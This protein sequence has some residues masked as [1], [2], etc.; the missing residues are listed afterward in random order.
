MAEISAALVKELRERTGAGMMECKQALVRQKGDLEAAVEDLR[1]SGLAKAD[2]KAG[3]QTAEGRIATARRDDATVLLEVN[4][5]TDFVGKD[6]H[7]V[8]FADRLAEL[9]VRH[10]SEDTVALSALP[11]PQGGTVE[12]ARRHLVSRLGEN[13]TLRRL[14]LSRWTQGPRDVYL[15]GHR[16]G[17]LVEL[18]GGDEELAHDIAMH[19]AASRPL[20]VRPDEVPAERIEAERRIFQAQAAESGKPP[21]IVQKMVEG[22]VQKFLAEVT[23]LG[24]PF[25]KDPQTT[26]GDLL[27]R[28]KASVHAFVRMELGEGIE[29]RVCDFAEDVRAQLRS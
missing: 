16:I 13:I 4:C 12:D 8:S 5:E 15:H 2:K 18:E 24:Q 26:V 27:R 20:C 25:V 9:A 22:R 7:F 10:A 29:R 28:R 1:T 19:V 3:R 14:A 11:W 6:E 23:L 21:A 17:V